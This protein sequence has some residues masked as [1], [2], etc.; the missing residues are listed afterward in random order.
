[1]DI[2]SSFAILYDNL[3]ASDYLPN[4]NDPNRYKVHDIQKLEVPLKLIF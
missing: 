3:M 1:M 2:S 4:R